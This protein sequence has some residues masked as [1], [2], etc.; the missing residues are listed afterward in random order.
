MA[1][2]NMIDSI[3]L[4]TEKEELMLYEMHFEIVSDSKLVASTAP[5]FPLFCL[6]APRR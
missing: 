4:E 1:I 2:R 3:A 6:C 5:A